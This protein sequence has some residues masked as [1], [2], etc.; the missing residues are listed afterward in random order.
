MSRGQRLVHLARDT[1]RTEFEL[2]LFDGGL[3]S[4]GDIGSAPDKGLAS[5]NLWTGRATIDVA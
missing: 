2:D 3:G 1:C 4:T 5:Q